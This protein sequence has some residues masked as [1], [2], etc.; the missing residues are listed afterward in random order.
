MGKVPQGSD[1]GAVECRLVRVRGR[2]QG[3]GFRAACMD[4]ALAQGI[5][6]WVRN[7]SDGSVEAMLQGPSARLAEMCHWLHDGVRAARVTD[8]TVTVVEPDRF[9]GFDC[10]PTV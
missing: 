10:R 3:V 2:V 7:R 6:G 1:D 8:L 5:C 9:E 4:H